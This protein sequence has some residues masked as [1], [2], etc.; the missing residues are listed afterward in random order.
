MFTHAPH[1]YNDEHLAGLMT[2]LFVQIVFV[3]SMALGSEFPDRECC[4]DMEKL[5]SASASV[6]SKIYEIGTTDIPGITSIL[7]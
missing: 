2:F 4:D 5:P 3:V 6:N 1:N 7:Y